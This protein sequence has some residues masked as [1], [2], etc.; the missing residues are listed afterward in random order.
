MHLYITPSS[1]LLVFERNFT[2]KLIPECKNA[3]STSSRI[4]IYCIK[5][6]KVPRNE[7]GFI[8]T[9]ENIDN[10]IVVGHT[11]N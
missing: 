8:Q 7:K 9:V 5:E 6:S 10:Q 2:E 11:L 4:T 1:K 3:R